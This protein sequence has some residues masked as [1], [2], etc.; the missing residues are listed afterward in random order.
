MSRKDRSPRSLGGEPAPRLSDER[1]PCACSKARRAGHAV[2]PTRTGGPRLG[3]GAALDGP[4]RWA[5]VLSAP[6]STPRRDGLRPDAD[7]VGSHGNMTTPRIAIIGAGFAGLGMAVRLLEANI[8][9]F[10]IYERSDRI[11]GNWRAKDYPGVC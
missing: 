6:R 1:S 8:H 10:T 11:G 2:S 3:I 5:V 9:D 7:A 4:A